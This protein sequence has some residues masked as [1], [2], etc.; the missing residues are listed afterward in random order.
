M[1]TTMTLSRR[2]A[3]QISVL[4]QPAEHHQS[5]DRPNF[6]PAVPRRG[7][8][9]NASSLYLGSVAGGCGIVDRKQHMIAGQV[10]HQ[11]LEVEA[12]E[13][14]GQGIGVPAGSPQRVVGG[15][16]A[17]SAEPGRNSASSFGK[18]GANED[19]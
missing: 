9:V 15:A 12:E 14:I 7:V 4:A 11:R 18:E 10:T 16:E 13:A 1:L 17:G 3:A 8:V 6:S 5:Q 2:H 19:L